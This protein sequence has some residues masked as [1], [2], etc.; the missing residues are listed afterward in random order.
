M[1][2][3][4]SHSVGRLSSD[5]IGDSGAH[6]EMIISSRKVEV[7]VGQIMTGVYGRFVTKSRL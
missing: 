6:S 4:R 1:K 5:V 3:G 7:S 2:S